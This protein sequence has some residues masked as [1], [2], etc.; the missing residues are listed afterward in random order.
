MDTNAWMA[1]GGL[2]VALL[3]GLGSVWRLLQA[4]V[5]EVRDRAAELEAD[6]RVLEGRVEHLESDLRQ[7]VE[8][9]EAAMARLDRDVRAVLTQQQLPPRPP[10]QT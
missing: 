5:R 9:L 2:S 7:A 3:G 8:R 4:Q 1:L 6:G 10:T